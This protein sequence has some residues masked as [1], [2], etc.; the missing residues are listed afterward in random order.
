MDPKFEVIGNG[1]N[2]AV[3]EELDDLLSRL[4]N[5]IEEQAKRK[6]TPGGI[7]VTFSYRYNEEID[8]EADE[9]NVSPYIN[10]K[11]P[12]KSLERQRE[13]D[14]IVIPMSDIRIQFD[15]PLTRP[16]IYSYQADALEGFTRN[17]LAQCVIAGYT[18]IYN[19]ENDFVNKRNHQLKYG[20]CFMWHLVVKRLN[21]RSVFPAD[22][23][24][25][26]NTYCIVHP[27]QRPKGPFML[28]RPTT[29][30]P[31]G[32]W[33]HSLGD[34]ELHTVEQVEDNLFVLGVDS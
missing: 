1:E 3:P 30:G 33:G 8:W 5:S 13:P 24:R 21:L 12:E 26:I 29:D 34:L 27:K 22:L 14:A 4:F 9:D 10:L 16:V 20:A 18:Q 32:I 19:E 7:I 2:I 25:L 17:H 28:N 31:H 15:Y 11:K 6:K 23:I